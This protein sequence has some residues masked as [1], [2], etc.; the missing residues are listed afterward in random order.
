MNDLV[1][2][3]AEAI[4]T[5]IEAHLRL[6]GSLDAG[7]AARAAIAIVTK[8]C[9]ERLEELWRTEMVGR[10]TERSVRKGIIR[11]GA[12]RDAARVVSDMG[13]AP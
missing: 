12:L 4:L 11:R 7:P 10:E 5:Q 13:E 8:T 9:S 2:D 3:V 6:D 1:D